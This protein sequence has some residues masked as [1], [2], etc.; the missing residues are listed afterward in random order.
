MSH[1][2]SFQNEDLHHLYEII[3][4]VD[5]D[6]FKYGISCKPIDEQ[7]QSSRM[8]EQVNPSLA[9]AKLFDGFEERGKI[10]FH[11]E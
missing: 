8:R 5:D 10:H 9:R 4:R 11:F 7:G 2:N 3:D 6:V 1:K